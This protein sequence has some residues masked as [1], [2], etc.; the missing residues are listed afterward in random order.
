VSELFLKDDNGLEP[1]LE[2]SGLDEG[3]DSKGSTVRGA[4][5]RASKSFLEGLE[6]WLI[7]IDDCDIVWREIAPTSNSPSKFASASR[8]VYFAGVI[9]G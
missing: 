7:A 2:N 8:G 3:S 5:S 6:T 1:E 4:L 9:F